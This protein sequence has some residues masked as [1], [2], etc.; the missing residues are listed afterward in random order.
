MMNISAVNCEPNRFYANCTGVCHCLNGP[1]ECDPSDG[2]CLDYQCDRGWTG[3]PTCQQRKYLKK[4]CFTTIYL[5]NGEY[6][7]LLFLI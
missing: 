2:V 3:S 6:V 5:D 4:T 7:T 1:T